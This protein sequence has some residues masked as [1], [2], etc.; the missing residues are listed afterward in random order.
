VDCNVS[1]GAEGLERLRKNSLSGVGIPKEHSAGVKTPP[2][3]WPYR[4]E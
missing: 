1:R 2:F 4:H 3:L